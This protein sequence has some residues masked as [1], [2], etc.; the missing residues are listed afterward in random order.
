MVE[1]RYIY[2]ALFGAIFIWTINAWNHR[3]D[4]KDTCHI[5]LIFVITLATIVIRSAWENR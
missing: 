2:Y 4:E 1:F 3:T 5:T